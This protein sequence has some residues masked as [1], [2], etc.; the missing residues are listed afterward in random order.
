MKKLCIFGT[1]GFGREV[2]CCVMDIY[3]KMDISGLVCFMVDDA[4]Y[5]ES[6]V[7]GVDVIKR[8]QFDVKR[9]EMFIAV[10]D[11]VARKKIVES[12]P[13]ETE[14]ATIIHPSVTM[15]P[16]VQIGEGSIVTAGCI[17]TCNI[18]IG[19]QA[20]LNLHTTVGHDC[21]IGD[22]FTTAPAVN[23]SGN[24]K[25]GNEVYFGTNSSIKQGISVCS[26]ATIGMNAAVVKNIV[27]PGVYVGV[28]AKRMK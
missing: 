28:P 4:Y 8:S 2:L 3:D 6:K 25:I 24:C 27:E 19:K 7:L 20:H 26:G 5:S 12:F 10:G 22:F 17:L 11:S 9:H 1:G 13:S 23:I 14:F 18:I 16:F 15:S 21:V